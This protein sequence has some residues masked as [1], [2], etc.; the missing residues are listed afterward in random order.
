MANPQSTAGTAGHPVQPMLMS[1][2]FPIERELASI[3][4]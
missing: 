1:I 2:P 4:D 3:A